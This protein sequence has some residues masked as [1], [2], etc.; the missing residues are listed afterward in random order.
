MNCNE[1]NFLLHPRKLEGSE[2]EEFC[3]KFEVLDLEFALPEEQSDDALAPSKPKK[4]SKMDQ[5]K[6]GRRRKKR[7]SQTGEKKILRETLTSAHQNS[8]STSAI[9][10]K[11]NRMRTVPL[12]SEERSSVEFALE[13]PIKLSQMRSLDSALG[14]P[15]LPSREDSNEQKNQDV[16]SPFTEEEE[17]RMDV[18]EERFSRRIA[19]R[20][21]TTPRSLVKGFG[22]PPPLVSSQ[23]QSALPCPQPISPIASE[24]GTPRKPTLVNRWQETVMN[25]ETFKRSQFEK[26]RRELYVQR[27]SSLLNTH[28]RKKSQ[29]LS[30]SPQSSSVLRTPDRIRSSLALSSG[31]KSPIKRPDP[32]LIA[33]AHSQLEQL[34]QSAH[35]FQHT[36]DLLA[37]FLAHQKLI[38]PLL[39]C[40]EQL[41]TF[42]PE[43]ERSQQHWAEIQTD[44]NTPSGETRLPASI[45]SHVFSYLSPRALNRVAQTCSLWRTL[46]EQDAL[47]QAYVGTDLAS[48]PDSCQFVTEKT[49]KKDLCKAETL[50][51][52]WCEG[53]SF[54]V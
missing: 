14:M 19:G 42:L 15:I 3:L 21:N 43:A 52:Q 22:S 13:E 26:Q 44:M 54:P 16:A 8:V 36:F 46:S 11:K 30:H 1:L 39:P 10:P 35:A 41:R 47:W 33:T 7:R 20:A 25:D 31:D 45:W 34:I 29:L 40:V 12:G 48:I 17:P 2:Q 27:A 6:K 18:L 28:M 49:K 4:R 5:T 37:P 32:D 51:N 38:S 9:L 50:F 53:I 24:T 23:S